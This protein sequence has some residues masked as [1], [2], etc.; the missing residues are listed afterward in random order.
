MKKG[1]YYKFIVRAYKVVDGQEITLAVS[2]TI[3]VAT[4]G[5]KKGN[6]KAVDIKTD[7]SNWWCHILYW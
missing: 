3:H 6:A 5:G 1:K 2:K 4:N 7:R